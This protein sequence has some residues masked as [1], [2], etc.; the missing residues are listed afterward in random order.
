VSA[1]ALGLTV[2]SMMTVPFSLARYISQNTV[3]ATVRAGNFRLGNHYANFGSNTMIYWHREFFGAPYNNQPTW[4]PLDF[5]IYATNESEVAVNMQ[6]RFYTV[7]QHNAANWPSFSWSN[8]TH[9]REIPFGVAGAGQTNFE[10]ANNTNPRIGFVRAYSITTPAR[11]TILYEP[12]VGVLVHPGE[13]IEFIWSL[14]SHVNYPGGDT[15][16]MMD[17][18][19]GRGDINTVFRINYDIIATQVIEAD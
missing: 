8:T 19:Q 7:V 5:R 1:I 6:L 13:R 15:R 12:D 18:T 11:G 3:T 10:P 17:D 4:R 9:R 14:I 16:H 2:I